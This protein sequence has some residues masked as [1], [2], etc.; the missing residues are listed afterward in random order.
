ME[1]PACR[2]FG[3]LQSEKVNVF[4]AMRPLTPDDLVRLAARVKRAGE[5][6]IGDQR[7]LYLR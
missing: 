5:E 1:P 4:K 2:R 6:F 7:E 3:A